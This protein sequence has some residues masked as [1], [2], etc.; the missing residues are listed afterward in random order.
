MGRGVRDGELKFSPVD[1]SNKVLLLN[2][3]EYQKM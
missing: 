2:S 3:K 1:K